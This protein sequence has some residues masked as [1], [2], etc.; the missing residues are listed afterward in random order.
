MGSHEEESCAK[1]QLVFSFSLAGLAKAI[2]SWTTT[3]GKSSLPV[4][5]H[6]VAQLFKNCQRL[7]T[8]DSIPCGVM[9]DQTRLEIAGTGSGADLKNIFDE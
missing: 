4:W 7:G 3:C 2:F 1:E 8:S 5:I 6:V 9:R